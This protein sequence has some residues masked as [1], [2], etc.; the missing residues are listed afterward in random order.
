MESVIIVA[1]HDYEAELVARLERLGRLKPAVEGVY[2]FEDRGS[3]V[4]LT[5]DDGVRNEY[6]PEKLEAFLKVF[7]EPIFYG[8]DFSDIVL[9]RRALAEIADD[10]KL[11]VDNDHGVVLPGSEFVR[12][13]RSRPDWDWRL[14]RVY[15]PPEDVE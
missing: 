1:P 11:L 14:D 10:S 9:C 3:R 8:L 6:E 13:L 2:V 7:P 4:Y 15:S 12:L 5:R